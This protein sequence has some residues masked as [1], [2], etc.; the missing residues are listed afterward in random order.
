MISGII[1]YM[2]VR[3][4]YQQLKTLCIEHCRSRS[5]HVQ[6]QE[7]QNQLQWSSALLDKA[8]LVLSVW[9]I[10]TCY[11]VLRC[12]PQ[13]FVSTKPP[14]SSSSSDTVC[15]WLDA[16][17][18]VVH[19]KVERASCKIHLSAGH[20]DWITVTVQY[21]QQL[22]IQKYIHSWCS[23]WLWVK[24]LNSEVS[25]PRQNDNSCFLMISF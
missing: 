25:Y 3:C 1:S 24:M 20:S 9:R 22:A 13:S 11:H 10:Q 14:P 15:T 2:M 19:I 21:G 8:R 12:V 5:L 4:L 6:V 18:S 16:V 7:V 17:C 23:T